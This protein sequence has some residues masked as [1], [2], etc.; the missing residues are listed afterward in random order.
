VVGSDVL[1]PTCDPGD[2][3]TIILFG[4]GAGAALLGSSAEPGILSTHLHADGR[5]VELLT[6][7]NADR[8]D[9][10]NPIYLTMAGNE[11]CK[12]AVTE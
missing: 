3:G 9:P 4:D 6:L 10:D 11:V 5:Y 2:R 12:V 8:V 7:P 1:A